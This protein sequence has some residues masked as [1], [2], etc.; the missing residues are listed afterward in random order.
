MA[1]QQDDFTN[2]SSKSNPQPLVPQGAIELLTVPIS[3]DLLE[4]FEHY[5][6]LCEIVYPSLPNYIAHSK[7]ICGRQSDYI[8][9]LA[10]G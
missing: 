3:E 9:K 6:S 10:M 7:A 4:Q 8:T 2:R 1:N 5:A